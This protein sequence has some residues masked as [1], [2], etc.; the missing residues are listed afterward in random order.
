MV[1]VQSA[2]PLPTVTVPALPTLLPSVSVQ[3]PALPQLPAVGGGT[4]AA[5]GGAGSAPQGG[6]TPQAGTSAQVGDLLAQVTSGAA[7]RYSFGRV[8]LYS[9]AGTPYAV[10]GGAGRGLSPASLY[11]SAVPG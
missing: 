1:T 8:P 4:P 7:T 6:S 2:V 5:G 3:V 9:Y 10:A 11:G